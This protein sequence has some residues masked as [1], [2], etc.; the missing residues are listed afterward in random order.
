VSVHVEQTH[1]KELGHN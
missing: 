1:T